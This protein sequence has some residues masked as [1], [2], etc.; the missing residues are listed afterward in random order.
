MTRKEDT[1]AETPEERK[2]RLASFA[3]EI[4]AM[5]AE[6]PE[7]FD[8]LRETLRKCGFATSGDVPEDKYPMVRTW[9]ALYRKGATV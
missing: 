7:A 2:E 3:S 5:K 4:R 8:K 9:Y 6:C 1:P